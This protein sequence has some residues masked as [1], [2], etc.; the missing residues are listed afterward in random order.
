MARAAKREQKEA[1]LQQATAELSNGQHNSIQKAAAAHN[2]P[3]AM[4]Q[5]HMAGLQPKAKA[6]SSQQVLTP[7]AEMALVEYIQH[8][9]C[10][11]YPLTPALL[12][13]YTDAI[14]QPVPGRSQPVKLGCSWL[15]SFLI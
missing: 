7:A 6:Q 4:L 3:E 14:T 2:V 15:Q 8:C 11:R 10:S 1:Q 12:R 13:E 9:A 5:Q